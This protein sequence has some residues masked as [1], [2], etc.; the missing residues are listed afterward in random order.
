[1]RRRW[2]VGSKRKERNMEPRHNNCELARSTIGLFVLPSLKMCVSYLFV[3]LYVHG[4]HSE[5][6]RRKI[7]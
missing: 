5:G 2:G 4:V 6:R 7:E 3:L 1:M